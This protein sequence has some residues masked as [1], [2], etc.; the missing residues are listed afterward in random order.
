MRKYDARDERSIRVEQLVREWTQ[1]G[2][3]QKD[4]ETAILPELKVDLRRTNFFFR[5]ILLVFG[6]LIIWSSVW[7][8]RI[9]F[10]LREDVPE[11][12]LFAFG[13]VASLFLGEFLITRFRL[14]RFGVEEAAAAAAASLAA[15]AVGILAFSR[16]VAMEA[17]LGIF[18][19]LIAG[20]IAAFAIYL[21]FG[22]IY[23][24]AVSMLCMFAAPFA[25]DWPPVIQRLSCEGL[26]LAVFLIARRKSFETGDEF[27]GDEYSAIQAM[28]WL[29]LYSSFNLRLP[30]L[31]QFTFMTADARGAFYW[32]TYMVIWILPVIGLF[33]ALRHRQRLLLDV[34]LITALLTLATN[35]PYLGI[36]RQTWDPILLGV[37]L[38]GTAVAVRRWLSI[39]DWN[40]FTAERIL[41]WDKR[42]ISL[43]ATA[44]AALHPA[45][46]ASSDST[47]TR[48]LEPGGGRSG[49]AGAS[50]TL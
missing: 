46:Q 11:A 35:K 44:S 1:S 17:E 8:I 3:L 15:L 19:T 26:F 30:L 4:Q 29:G 23:A 39:R 7:L 25:M 12:I 41:S 48:N 2:L 33:L 49:G 45:S 50:G 14:Y 21:R 31:Q 28:A 18:L 13:A 16:N 6:L 37:L 22:Y 24:A 47:A 5:F 10:G 20:A 9:T 42:R 27:P 34:S 43:V 32:L 36:A 38:I 40:G